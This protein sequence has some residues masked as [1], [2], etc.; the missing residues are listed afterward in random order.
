MRRWR[1]YILKKTIIVVLVVIS[2]LCVMFFKNL[3]LMIKNYDK[4]F[5]YLSSKITEN[6]SVSLYYKKV[7][8]NP[9]RYKKFIENVQNGK[10]D[11]LTLIS[12][13]EKNVNNFT[14]VTYD[15]KTIKYS[16]NITYNNETSGSLYVC[17]GLKQKKMSDQTVYSLS[18]CEDNNEYDVFWIK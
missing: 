17:K 3:A 7:A 14:F 4:E 18:G 11:A 10:G 15:G 8:S 9:E 12:F 16:Q 2:I 1:E 5:Y 13:D 6:I